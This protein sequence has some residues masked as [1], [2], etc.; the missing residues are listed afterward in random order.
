MS[1]ASADAR[2]REILDLAGRLADQVAPSAA[3]HDLAGTFPAEKI[4]AGRATRYSH[5]TLPAELAGW[6]AAFAAV[7]AAHRRLAQ[8]GAETS[9][10]LRRH[11]IG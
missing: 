10:A 5:L 3:E 2:R 4:A 11:F 8:G 6:G 1:K 9:F 7:L